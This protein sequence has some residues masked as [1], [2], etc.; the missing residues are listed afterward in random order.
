MSGIRRS[1]RRGSSSPAPTTP[2]EGES[3]KVAIRDAAYT[4]GRAD[5]QL[6]RLSR[7]AVLFSAANRTFGA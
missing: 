2:T 4:P 7:M 3:G 1:I 6:Y 5:R